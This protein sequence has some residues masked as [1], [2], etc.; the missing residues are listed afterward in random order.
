MSIENVSHLKLLTHRDLVN[1]SHCTGTKRTANS[2]WL[3]M[4][5]LTVS[6]C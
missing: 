2:L 1:K 6:I 5:M 4:L 3:K